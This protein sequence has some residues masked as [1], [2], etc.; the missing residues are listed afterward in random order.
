MFVPAFEKL[1]R[2]AEQNRTRC[3]QLASA[4]GAVLSPVLKSARSHDGDGNVR[5][6]LL[7]WP[8]A[9][10]GGAHYIFHA[11]AVALGQDAPG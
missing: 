8:V 10:A 3:H 2:V 11:P 4:A 7:E 9:R 1:T 5:M 6:P